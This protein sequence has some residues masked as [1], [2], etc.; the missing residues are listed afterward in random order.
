MTTKKIVTPKNPL[1][2]W[3]DFTVAVKGAMTFNEDGSTS[4][5]WTAP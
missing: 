5:D 1:A 3:G 4:F 2:L